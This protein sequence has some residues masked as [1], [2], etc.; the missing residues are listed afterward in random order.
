M[1][2]ILFHS[3]MG[4]GEG[5]ADAAERFRAA[6]HRVHT[7]D[8]YEGVAFDDYPEADAHVESIGG[9]PELIR[10]TTESIARYPA[11][12][13]YAGFS[14]GGVSALFAGISRPGARG[15]LSFHAAIPL[16]M[17]GVDAWP[18]AVPVQVHYAEHDPK[19]RQ[20]WIDQFAAS[21]RAAGAGYQF[22]EYLGVTGH[23]F[24]DPSREREYDAAAA[25][26]MFERSLAFLDRVSG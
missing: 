23:L 20:E 1:E 12:V 11:D 6:G 16:P 19:R 3:V 5:V 26:L 18:P 4:V 14:N 10:R 9:P 7:I 24:A 17:M 2:I 13:V 21:V 25:K 8:L 22:F 15:V